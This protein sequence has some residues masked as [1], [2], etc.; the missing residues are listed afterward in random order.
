[1]KKLIAILAVFAFLGAALFAQD[2]GSWSLGGSGNFGFGLDMRPLL[3]YG[4]NG[5][6]DPALVGGTYYNYWV[7]GWGPLKAQLTATYKKG[8]LSTGLTFD[9]TE[10]LNAFMTF[11][12]DNYTFVAEQNLRN[13]INMFS[14]VEINLDTDYSDPTDPQFD[15]S[16]RNFYYGYGPNRLWGHYMFLDGMLKLEVAVKSRD[17]QFWNA[18][19][20][21]DDTLTKVDGANYVVFDVTPKSLVE[22]LNFGFMFPNVFSDPSK[23]VTNNDNPPST[24]FLEETLK[25]WT[26]G[27]KYGSGPLNLA[28]Q[29]GLRGTIAGTSYINNNIHIGATYAISSELSAQFAVQGNL[30]K[31]FDKFE[32]GKALYKDAADIRIGGRLNYASGPFSIRLDG[33]YSNM[34]N[35]GFQS[36]IE[37]LRVRALAAYVLI[38]Q[39]LRFQ[40][41]AR[42]DLPLVEKTATG[43]DTYINYRIIPELFF[44][45]LGT[46]IGDQWS[47][48]TGFIARYRLDGVSRPE[49]ISVHA[50]DFAFKFS[51]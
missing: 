49:A 11:N 31:V 6:H 22:G 40:F 46:G 8:G 14:R 13:L 26:F 45:F 27:A 1:M 38:P 20:V 12:G 37:A 15:L 3:G 29:Y 30:F 34:R 4:M 33:I 41:D 25:K 5:G 18:A 43:G 19:G 51:F 50:L 10:Q 21:L 7:D 28:F 32:D 17:T 2:E 47:F 48:G 23:R 24:D 44:N 42:V 35:G 9:T 36:G 39:Q 16:A